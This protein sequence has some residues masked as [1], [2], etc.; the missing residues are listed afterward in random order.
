MKVFTE[1]K[2]AGF[3]RGDFNIIRSIYVR[4]KSDLKEAVEK[5]GFPCVAKAFGER[6]IHKS[7]LGGVVLNIKNYEGVSKSFDKF[8][9]IKG[10]EGVVLQEQ[11]KGKELLVGIK[12]TP[13]FGHV[14]IFGA[15]GS[16][17][18][19]LKDVSFRVC[20]FDKKDAREMID[21]VE[22]SKNLDEK[23]KKILVKVL[24]RMCKLVG[25]HRGISELDINP[26]IIHKGKEIILDSRIVWE[27]KNL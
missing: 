15:G 13:E 17:V 11:I 1:R 25:K 6:I 8:G 2:S 12:K 9:K 4:Q 27:D 16:D 22:F 20:D 24:L 19:K 7:K 10:F 3:L 5:I 21:E 23:E 14:V 26:L 18:E